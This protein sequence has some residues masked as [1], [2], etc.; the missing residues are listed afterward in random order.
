MHL[1]GAALLSVIKKNRNLGNYAAGIHSL[2][3]QFQRS[4]ETV[5]LYD[6]VSESVSQSFEQVTPETSK[7]PQLNKKDT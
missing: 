6:A 2:K 5:R 1:A 3:Q 4:C 7:T